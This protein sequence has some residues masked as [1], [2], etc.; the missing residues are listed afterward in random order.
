MLSSSLNLKQFVFRKNNLPGVCARTSLLLHS[1]QFP[2]SCLHYFHPLSQGLCFASFFLTLPVN[3]SSSPDNKKDKSK[4][5][6]PKPISNSSLS[7]TNEGIAVM[8]SMKLLFYYDSGVIT[9]VGAYRGKSALSVLLTLSVAFAPT[10][11]TSFEF[12]F[13]AIL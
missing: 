10:N 12:T 9:C 13:D 4:S 3:L 6:K 2:V 7:E 11:N 5:A 8:G 1:V